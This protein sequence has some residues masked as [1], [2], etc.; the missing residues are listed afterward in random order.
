MIT[1]T[2]SS[3]PGLYIR[4]VSGVTEGNWLSMHL[5]ALDSILERVVNASKI[6]FNGAVVNRNRDRG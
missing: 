2:E 5:K 1:Q 3:G 6:Q 4:M